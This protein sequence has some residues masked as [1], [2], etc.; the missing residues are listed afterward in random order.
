[1]DY[2]CC[3]LYIMFRNKEK[4]G[5]L[6]Q[7]ITDTLLPVIDED[8]SLLDAPNHSNIGDSLIYEG[9]LEFLKRS[10][11]RKLFAS[12][13]K[14][15]QLSALPEEGLLLFHGGG[16]FGDLW[17]R[18]QKCRREVIAARKRQKILIF[19]QTVFYENK[20]NLKADAAIFNSHPDLTICARD[21]NSFAIL[22]Q[23]FFNN[24][25]LLLPDMAFCLDLENDH[26][27]QSSGKVLLMKR[28]DKEIKTTAIEAE[29]MLVGEDSGKQVE[30][31]DWP[32]MELTK[33]QLIRKKWKD[34]ENKY[35]TRL[36]YKLNAGRSEMDLN[37][38]I[39]HR[40]QSYRQMRLGIDFLNQYDSI[41]STRLHGAILGLLLDKQVYLIDNSYG[42]NSSF[43]TCWL[44]DFSRCEML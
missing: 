8:Y 7:K 30:V 39:R 26:R 19:P 32:G 18:F 28:T 21:L 11:R 4:I 15:L 42:K 20:E 35:A 38:G 2:I 31:K 37:F 33:R 17:P 6:R 10:P 36:R 40:Y 13:I 43:Y 24:K 22:K 44:T 27:H 1:M 16:N 14:F 12:S 3:S 9:E 23:Y 34:R 41:Y 5:C 25:I 29:K